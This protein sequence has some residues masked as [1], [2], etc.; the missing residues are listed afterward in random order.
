MRNDE[1]IISEIT[2]KIIS[3]IT[4]ELEGKRLTTKQRRFIIEYVK[5]PKG[6]EAAR[7]AGYSVKCAHQ[8]AYE[9]LRKPKLKKIV[10]RALRAWSRAIRISGGYNRS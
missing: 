10:D 7:R 8:Q 9:N 4:A 3:K 6:A 1:L 2:A 5:V